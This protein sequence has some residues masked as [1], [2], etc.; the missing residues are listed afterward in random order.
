MASH[1]TPTVEAL[2]VEVL[3][4]AVV[5]ADETQL[6]LL[7][8]PGASKW[9]A[10]SAASEKALAYRILESRSA[11][12]A[13]TVL[14]SFD[15][16]LVTRHRRLHRLPIATRRPGT[17]KRRAMAD[18]TRALLGAYGASFTTPNR[19]GRKPKRCWFWIRDLYRVESEVRDLVGEERRL[20]L[21]ELRHARSKANV[22][23]IGMWLACEPVLPR[24]GP[25][26]AISYAT[27][28]WD[29][30]VR[31]LDDARIPLDT[32][33]VERG[34]RPVAVGR[35]NHYGSKSGRGMRPVA[36][37]RKNQYSSKSGRGMRPV[38]VGRKNQYSSKSGR[39]TR[40]AA[41]FYT[42]IELAKHLGVEPAGYLATATRR[43]IENL[44]TVTLPRQ[45]SPD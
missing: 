6:P 19:P 4:S 41:L 15:G 38:A 28:H 3:D 11:E 26:K 36:G 13:L 14:E 5:L 27:A 23:A 40:V 32:N 1:L 31:F 33:L 16:I 21:G 42:L 18:C 37:G 30:L 12:A 34:M 17:R 10:W 35:K 39:G 22:A 20:R 44:G 25:R 7:D 9:Y 24:S 43:A 29:G 45:L 8:K 2:W